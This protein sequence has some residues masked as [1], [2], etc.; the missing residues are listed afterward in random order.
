MFSHVMYIGPINT[1]SVY[2]PILP[3]VLYSLSHCSYHIP[4]KMA[5]NVLAIEVMGQNMRAIAF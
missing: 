4:A 1:V 3:V 2:N 5:E